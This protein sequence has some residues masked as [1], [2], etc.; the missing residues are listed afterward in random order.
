MTKPTAAEFRDRAINELA[1]EAERKFNQGVEQRGRHLS[2][3]AAIL[4][5]NCYE[6]IGQELA[7]LPFYWKALGWQRRRVLE[8]IYTALGD[9]HNWREPLMR[10][11][12]LME[13]GKE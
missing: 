8:L 13:T 1:S 9:S 10:A 6:E 12:S 11:A 4:S 5:E 2:M 3:E 7:D